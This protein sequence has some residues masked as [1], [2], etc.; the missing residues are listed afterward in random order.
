MALLIYTSAAHEA[1]A[2]R[3]GDRIGCIDADAQNTEATNQ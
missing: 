2:G 1:V 3:K